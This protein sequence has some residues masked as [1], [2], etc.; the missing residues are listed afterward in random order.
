[1]A[2]FMLDVGLMMIMMVMSIRCTHDGRLL[3]SVSMVKLNGQFL[4]NALHESV[5]RISCP[6]FGNSV[7]RSTFCRV[8]SSLFYMSSFE[9]HSQNESFPANAVKPYTWFDFSILLEVA[10]NTV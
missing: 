9:T 4:I 1:M 3:K 5:F 2:M 7:R 10:A 6:R 8:Y